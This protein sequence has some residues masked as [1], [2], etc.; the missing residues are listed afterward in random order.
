MENFEENEQE[1][2]LC[3]VEETIFVAVGRNIEKS[4]TT[5]FWAVQ[6]FAG[7]KICLLHVHKPIQVVAAFSELS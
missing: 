4:K 2:G 5:L 1:R 3:D 6:N 7:K